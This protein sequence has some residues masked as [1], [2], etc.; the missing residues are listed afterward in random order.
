M[1]QKHVRYTFLRRLK[2][3]AFLRNIR[4][5]RNGLQPAFWRPK[6]QIN[7]MRL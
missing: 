7:P 2:D 1:R 4:H 5:R 6:P 3:P